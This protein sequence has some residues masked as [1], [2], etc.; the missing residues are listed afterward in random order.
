MIGPASQIWSTPLRPICRSPE[1]AQTKKPSWDLNWNQFLV[2]QSRIWTVV[3]PKKVSSRHISIYEPP[4]GGPVPPRGPFEEN[5]NFF[6][7]QLIIYVQRSHD[8]N[9]G[10]FGKLFKPP[11]HLLS[12]L[13]KSVSRGG[14]GVS[15]EWGTWS[16]NFFSKSWLVWSVESPH[17]VWRGFVI[18]TWWKWLA[19]KSFMS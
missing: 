12:F 6:E 2:P 10:H 11:G 18:F 7:F 15:Q 17:R 9:L 3:R 19:F 13:S 5:F 1:V 4:N 14:F 16:K 8:A